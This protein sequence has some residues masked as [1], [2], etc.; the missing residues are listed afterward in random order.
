MDLFKWGR[1]RSLMVLVILSILLDQAHIL[2]G[3]DPCTSNG[4]CGTSEC[5]GS[6]CSAVLSLLTTLTTLTCLECTDF[7]T[8]TAE[9]VNLQYL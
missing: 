3:A 2:H 5:N 4:A 9:A 8:G 7:P 1:E 6:S